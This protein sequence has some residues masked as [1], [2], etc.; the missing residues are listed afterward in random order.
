MIRVSLGGPGLAGFPPDF[1]G[2]YVKLM[3][4]PATA[5]GKPVVRTYTIRHQAEDAIAIANDSP[6]GLGAAV[7]SRDE[8]KA[9]EG[10]DRA[11]AELRVASQELR[12]ANRDLSDFTAAAA[13][14]L[15]G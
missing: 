2:G 1:A 4:A 8:A 9:R 10:A 13:H 12:L 11:L 3:L 7:F 14:D 6:F 5:G 15:R